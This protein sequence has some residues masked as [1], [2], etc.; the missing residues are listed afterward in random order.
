MKQSK[1]NRGEKLTSYDD[2]DDD[3]GTL[4]EFRSCPNKQ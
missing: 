1:L 4:K 2:D 3:D